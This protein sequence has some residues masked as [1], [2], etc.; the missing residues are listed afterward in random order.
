VSR[1]AKYVTSYDTDTHVLRDLM[2]A[3]VDAVNQEYMDLMTGVE[4][5]D[6]THA[7]KHAISNK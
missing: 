5:Y 1:F 6:G 2:P 7:K 4:V 3:A